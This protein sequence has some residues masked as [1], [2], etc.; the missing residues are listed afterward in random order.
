MVNL[1]PRREPQPQSIA[2]AHPTHPW[3]QRI[4][5]QVTHII[6]DALNRIYPFLQRNSHGQECDFLIVNG[7]NY[8]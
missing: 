6:E 8:R 1:F 4:G 3:H 7:N 5:E 2:D